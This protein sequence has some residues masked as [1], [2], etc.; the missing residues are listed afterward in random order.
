MPRETREEERLTEDEIARR[1]LGPRGVPGG[2]DTAKM[3][4]PTGKEY[5]QDRRLRRPYRLIGQS[6]GLEPRDQSPSVAQPSPGTP[7]N[8]P[9]SVT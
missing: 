5:S 2:P 1:N 9:K 3:T 6:F 7:P 8:H 4:P